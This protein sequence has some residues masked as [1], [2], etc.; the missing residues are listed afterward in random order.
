MIEPFGIHEVRLANDARIGI[1][2][3]P[4]RSGDLAGDVALIAAW[5]ATIVVSMTEADE[6][7]ARGAGD[8]GEALEATRISWR[9][10]PIRDFGAPEGFETR[11]PALSPELH[12]ALDAGKRILV[13]CAGGCGRSGMVA[14][15]L[16][17]ERGTAPDDAL[18]T[19][20]AAR[21]CAVEKE[22]QR[23]WAAAGFEG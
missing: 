8:L 17:C 2:R 15:R 5:P 9:H 20:R 12:A 10:F 1:S 11:W 18:A 16:L 7:A 13:H 14:M 6:M 21:P 22:K 23:L 4:G 3:M 19:V